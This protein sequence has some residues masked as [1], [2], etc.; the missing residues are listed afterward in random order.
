MIGDVEM[1]IGQAQDQ[2]TFLEYYD[3]GHITWMIARDM[4][5]LEDISEYFNAR[6]S[7]GN[8]NS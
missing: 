6:F 3:Q 4:S 1:F 5:W 7:I 8:D 2:I